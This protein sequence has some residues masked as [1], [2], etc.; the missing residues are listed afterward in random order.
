MALVSMADQFKGLPIEVLIGK[1][2]EAACDSQIMLAN[3]TAKFI[4]DVGFYEENGVSKTRLADFSF[5]K[6]IVTGKDALGHDIYDKQNVKMQVPM[7][8]IVNIPSLQVQTVDVTFDMEVKS[9]ESL[10]ASASEKAS[11]RGGGSIGYGIFS[12]HVSVSGSISSHQEF[13]RKSDNSAKYHI[14]VHAE[15]SGTPEGLSR[16]LDIIAAAVAPSAVEGPQ[17]RED[18]KKEK[19]LKPLANQKT[20]LE[21]DIAQNNLKIEH[22]TEELN[23]L[24]NKK[25][26]KEDSDYIDAKIAELNSLKGQ[27]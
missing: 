6:N 1:P 20:Q 9:S 14:S 3:S 7:L 25:Q 12:V 22:K 26:A 17:Q 24:K 13:T 16:V 18:K 21:N 27:L 19:A 15:Q 10:N 8:A 11:L 2:L 5:D 23:I 4:E